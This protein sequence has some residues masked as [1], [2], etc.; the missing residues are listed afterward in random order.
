[1]KPEDFIVEE[2]INPEK[3]AGDKCYLYILTKKN[4]ESLKALSY[5]S[6]KFKIPLKDIGYCGL[7]DRHAITKQYIS[8]PK[9]YKK[10]YL[11]EPNLKLK[12]I[13]ISRFLLLGDLEG[14]KFTITI[15]GIKKEDIPKLEENLKY[16]DM[17]APNYFDSQRFGSVFDGKFIAKEII[18]GNIEEAVKILLTRYKKSEKKRIKDL[19]RFISKNWGDWEKIW[20]YIK[21]NNIKAKMYVNIVKELKKSGDYKKAFN[22]VDDRLKK[23]F[24]SAYQ[25][26]LWNE[27]IKELLKEYIPKED[28]VYYEYECGSLLFYKK[29]DENSLNYLKN[30][31]F[32]MISPEAHYSEKE[33]KIIERVLKKENIKIEDLQKE[34]LKILGNFVRGERDVIS[35]P[36]NLKIGDIVE[37]DL[38]KGKYKI[39]LTFELK[40]GSYATI[41]IK[42]AFLGIKNKKRKK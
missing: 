7:K 18:M 5:I 12:P 41:I 29:L 28:R 11:E 25:S 38:V 8:I 21:E 19:K 42:R 2:I 17:G 30:L 16:L 14:N 22:Y 34:D 9:Y 37:D 40:K 36:K 35:I 31:K 24:L 6:K 3:I 1:M 27:C 26:Y 13:G 10:L 32:P 4:I 20:K 33:Q 39:T 23:L 15:R